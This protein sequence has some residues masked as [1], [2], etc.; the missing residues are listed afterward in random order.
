MEGP[1]TINLWIFEG[2]DIFVPN[3][4]KAFEAEHPNIK[5]NVT[6][7]PEDSYVTKIDTA[8]A[9]GR[10]P[11]IGYMYEPRWMKA[12]KVLPLDDVIAADNIDTSQYNQSAFSYC[13][14]DGS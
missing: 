5:I 4:V 8:L 12:G 9:A 13:Q 2:E 7:I 14:L 6:D 11:D 1:V 10:P 3:L